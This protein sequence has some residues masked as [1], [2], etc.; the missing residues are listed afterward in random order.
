MKKTVIALAVAAAMPMAAQADVTLSG[1]VMATYYGSTSAADR[2]DKGLD[3]DLDLDFSSVEVLTNG[4]TATASLDVN[5]GD[6]L[7]G[8]AGLEGD[9]GALT[10]GSALDADGAFQS[11]D[12]AG[13][14]A[15][16]TNAAKTSASTSNAIHY[17]GNM[18]GFDIE[19]Q[20]NAAT[21]AK[22]DGTDVNSALDK[23]FDPQTKSNQVGVT[24]ELLNGLKLGYGS[25]SGDADDKAK[26]TVGVNSKTE[27]IG[28]TYAMDDFD[29]TL[30]KQ[31]D[32][33][34]I[35][36]VKYNMGEHSVMYTRDTA[37]DTDRAGTTAS[38]GK[39]K[40]TLTYADDVDD[41]L[42]ATLIYNQN[43]DLDTQSKIDLEVSY[44]TGDLTAKVSREHDDT[45]DMSVA[46][47]MGNADL[48]LARDGSKSQTTVKYKVS[49]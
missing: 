31:K 40:I 21:K 8:K 28:L 20:V 35:A 15:D 44:V 39:D 34:T 26:H 41:G 18:S 5:K 11:G 17:S 42:S 48:T 23:Y 27:V 38:T 13:V 7:D 2:T 1:H 14:V 47:D 29:F 10:V 6:D 32:D 24:Y 37:D 33:D 4:M 12:V 30:G 9:F 19:V 49:F 25:A 36:S 3:V 16:T 46:Y 45:H 43:K 22:N